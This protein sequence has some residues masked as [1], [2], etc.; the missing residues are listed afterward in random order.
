ME[1]A[2]SAARGHASGREERHG[3]RP[4][5][6]PALGLRS[7]SEWPGIVLD[8]FVW[9]PLLLERLPILIPCAISV[10]YHRETSRAVP[11][12]P[13]FP[14]PY[15][16]WSMIEESLARSGAT[17]NRDGACPNVMAPGR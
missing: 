5:F 16:L 15:S 13:F 17:S 1:G 10:V 12:C 11:C 8:S 14:V 9:S 4:A 2:L 7:G 6:S 3:R